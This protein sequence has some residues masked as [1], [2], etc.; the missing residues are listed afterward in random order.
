[1]REN[2]PYLW[3]KYDDEDPNGQ[4]SFPSQTT[5]KSLTE[6]FSK[7]LPRT[8]VKNRLYL[9]AVM[10]VTRYSNLDSFSSNK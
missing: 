2:Y 9:Q 6:T 7:F 8:P 1:M 5:L 4:P 10:P 3:L